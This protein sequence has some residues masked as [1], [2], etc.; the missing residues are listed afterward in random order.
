MYRSYYICDHQSAYQ[1]YILYENFLYYRILGNEKDDH[2]YT[3]AL[4]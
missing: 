2:L 4:R 1:A 3:M